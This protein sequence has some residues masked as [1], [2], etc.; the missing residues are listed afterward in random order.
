MLSPI[1]K[2]L[3]GGAEL[4]VGQSP[5]GRILL[6]SITTLVAMLSLSAMWEPIGIWPAAVTI[7]VT[8]AVAPAYG[9][10]LVIFVAPFQQMAGLGPAEFHLLDGII[11]SAT[12]VRLAVLARPS[13]LRYVVW[14]PTAVFLILFAFLVIFYNSLPFGSSYYWIDVGFVCSLTVIVTAIIIPDLLPSYL[15]RVIVIA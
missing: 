1:A 10:A 8:L 9:L 4:P 15:P 5:V 11:W 2:L 6:L 12:A 14:S 3:V 7:L 13:D